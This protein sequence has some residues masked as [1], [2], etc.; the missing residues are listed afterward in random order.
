YH[1]ALEISFLADEGASLPEPPLKSPLTIALPDKASSLGKSISTIAAFAQDRNHLDKPG[2]F[3]E[4]F[5]PSP[6]DHQSILVWLSIRSVWKGI[7]FKWA[8]LLRITYYGSFDKP[9]RRFARDDLFAQKSRMV[10]ERGQS[11]G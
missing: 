8:H 5:P 11:G 10:T 3:K 1:L 6:S 9:L 7:V 4:D 2:S